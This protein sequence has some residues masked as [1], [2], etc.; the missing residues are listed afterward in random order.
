MKRFGLFALVLFGVAWLLLGMLTID[1]VPVGSSNDDAGYLLV[2]Q[3]FLRTGDITTTGVDPSGTAAPYTPGQPLVLALLSAITGGNWTAMHFLCLLITAGTGVFYFGLARSRLDRASAVLLAAAFLLQPLTYT[4]GSSFLSDM[5][6]GFLTAG[7]L[8]WCDK[9]EDARSAVAIG[10]AIGFTCMVR[11]SGLALGAAVALSLT[12]RGRYRES[13]VAA[14][15]T[16][17]VIAP[18]FLLRPSEQ[19]IPYLIQ[20]GRFFQGSGVVFSYPWAWMRTT[21]PLVGSFLLPWHGAAIGLLAVVVVLAALGARTEWRNVVPL[22]VI[23]YLASLVP[24]PY[25]QERYF[26]CWWPLLLLLAL[27]PLRVNA[28]LGLLGLLVLVDTFQIPAL[29]EISHLNRTHERDRVACYEWLRTHTPPDTIVLGTANATIS[30]FSDRACAPALFAPHFTDY[31]LLACQRTATYMLCEPM[32]TAQI[33]VFG[34]RQSTAPQR[35]DLWL[36]RSSLARLVCKNSTQRLFR[37]VVGR[38][39]FLAAYQHYL[40]ATREPQPAL[41]LKQ[42]DR[43]LSE[44]ADFPEAR[45]LRA[46]LLYKEG[47]RDA[48]IQLLIAEIVQYPVDM[49]AAT[50]LAEVLGE[51]GNKAAA[52]G[53]L[54]DARIRAVAL[55]FQADVA[56]IDA[57]L[58]RLR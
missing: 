25:M 46:A 6:F 30:L 7:V 15:S 45:R 40:D 11:I 24:W 47:R 22:F 39:R 55:E 4:Y 28:R 41:A 54:Q 13:L 19:H 17:L 56:R 16:G 34:A 32:S 29:L 50:Q 20:M 31:I 12:L 38:G 21:L 14:L 51:M 10:L 27:R 48:A 36:E 53:V 2:A 35:L 3:H 52:R 44:V 8:L 58:E 57:L 26:F 49:D 1:C 23:L 42:L 18:Y 9:V 43:C 5:N 33:D 37:R